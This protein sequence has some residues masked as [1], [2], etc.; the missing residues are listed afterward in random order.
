MSWTGR[1]VARNEWEPA[2]W[3]EP[4]H[5]PQSS[6]AKK[7]PKIVQHAYV[8]SLLA[9][10]AKTAYKISSLPIFQVLFVGALSY[11]AT[12]IARNIFE[13]YELCR[14]C[15]YAALGITNK[16]IGIRPIAA[17]VASIFLTTIPILSMSI[18]VGL[19]VLEGL[20]NDINYV[21]QLTS[22]RRKLLN[23]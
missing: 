8:G 6:L 4:T 15:E 17:L 11:A 9:T 23:Q 21:Q 2:V 1:G 13:E 20:T 16:V 14:R 7:Q 22:A 12:A 10:I 5:Q 19:G 18:A 3:Q